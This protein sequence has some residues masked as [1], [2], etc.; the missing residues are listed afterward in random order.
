MEWLKQKWQALLGG[1][2]AVLSLAF[3]YERSRRKSNEA[4]ADNFEDL[5]KLN[6]L[7]KQISENDGKIAAEEEKREDIRKEA[8]RDKADDSSDAT[9]FFKRR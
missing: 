5:N 4:I 9:E 8:E 3:L 6:E 2:V 7:N 1:L